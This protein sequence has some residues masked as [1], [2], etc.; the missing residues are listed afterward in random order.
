MFQTKVAPNKISHKKLFGRISLSTPGVELG[1]S[2]DLR[3][4]NIVMQW[5][6]K[7]NFRLNAAKNTGYVENASDK[8]CTD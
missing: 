7:V 8:S 1:V 5:N 4:W 6:E 2:K 3:F